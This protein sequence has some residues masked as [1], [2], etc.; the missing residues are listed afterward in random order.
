[1]VLKVWHF[2]RLCDPEETIARSVKFSHEEELLAAMAADYAVS[3]NRNHAIN[4][5]KAQLLSWALFLLIAS[6]ILFAGTS[7][8]LN[9]HLTY[10]K[11]TP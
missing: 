1:L 9:L 2:E 11:V 8:L 10:G 7:L 6:L 4:E 3:A 5:K